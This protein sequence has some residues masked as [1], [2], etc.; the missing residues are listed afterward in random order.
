[1]KLNNLFTEMVSR[2]LPC[3]WQLLFLQKLPLAGD[4]TIGKGWLVASKQRRTEV[5]TGWSRRSWGEEWLR[6]EPPLRTSTGEATPSQECLQLSPDW[7]K[8]KHWLLLHT[9]PAFYN[10]RE[11]QTEFRHLVQKRKCWLVFDSFQLCILWVASFYSQS[12]SFVSEWPVI[13]AICKR[14]WKH[15]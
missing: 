12:A 6:D 8:E 9:W 2:K 11:Q 7:V 4:E 13:V 5:A 10:M 15:S 1:M 3:G 14:N